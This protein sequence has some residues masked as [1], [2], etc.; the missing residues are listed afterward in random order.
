[1][2]EKERYYYDGLGED[3]YDS[4]IDDYP[5][6]KTICDTLNQQSKLIKEF[7]EKIKNCENCL[8]LDYSSGEWRK[9][10]DMQQENKQ[11][12]E[13]L[14]RYSELFKMKNK[15]FYGIEKSEY[16]KLQKGT[17]EIIK[18]S[19]KQL[20]IRELEKLKDTVEC[21]LNNALKNSSLNQSYYDRLLDEIDNQINKLKGEE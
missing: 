6:N 15:D 11:F 16:E 18:Q 12:K 20:A 5:S 19:Q 8:V 10:S 21:V 2:K 3:I 4:E 17:K 1:M 9:I 7:E 14:D 13:E